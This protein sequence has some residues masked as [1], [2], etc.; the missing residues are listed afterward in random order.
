MSDGVWLAIITASAGIVGALVGSLATIFGPSWWEAR[1]LRDA[2]DK[3]ESDARYERVET[4]IDAAASF[5]V[6]DTG[7]TRRQ[8]HVARNRLVSSLR[9][10][11]GNVGKYTHDV[12]AVITARRNVGYFVAN[13]AADKLFAWLRGEVSSEDLRADELWTVEPPSSTPPQS[14]QP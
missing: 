13:G 2:R 12:I 10:G 14:A 5:G 4:F 8:L 3:V 11:E 6:A 1:R 7:S 9:A